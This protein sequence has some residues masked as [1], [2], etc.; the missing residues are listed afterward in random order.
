MFRYF[1]LGVLLAA[2]A[3]PLMVN[4]EEKSRFSESTL[5]LCPEEFAQYEAEWTAECLVN[6][7]RAWNIR[8]LIEL[9]ADTT[10][11]ECRR[12]RPCHENFVFGPAPWE[13]APTDKRSLFDMIAT[14]RTISVDYVQDAE[15]SIEA[16]FY[17]GWTHGTHR[18]KPELSSANWMN[19]FFVCAM[20]FEPDLGV[21]LIADD[22]CHAEIGT[23]PPPREH[24]R[25]VKPLPGARS[26]SYSPSG[27]L[28]GLQRT[29]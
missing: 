13:G 21:W 29:L 5:A 4:A 8:A 14:A 28:S 3:F 26:A 27:N 23:T 22:F 18:A 17:P 10:T 11:F 25:Y 15:G 20:E 6:A 16:I 7:I 1:F 2:V 12:D 19:Q 24:D 9:T